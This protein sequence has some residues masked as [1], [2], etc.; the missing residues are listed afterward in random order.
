MTE[1]T[2][3]IRKR[4][5]Q[6]NVGIVFTVCR[7]TKKAYAVQTDLLVMAFQRGVGIV[8]ASEARAAGAAHLDLLAQPGVVLGQTQK[9][10]LAWEDLGIL[11]KLQPLCLHVLGD[12]AGRSAHFFVQIRNG[13]ALAV[14]MKAHQILRAFAAFGVKIVRSVIEKGVLLHFLYILSSVT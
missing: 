14:R 1:P 12:K 4:V 9:L 10:N 13:K 3:G 5:L 8:H 6:R 2:H 11:C 7:G